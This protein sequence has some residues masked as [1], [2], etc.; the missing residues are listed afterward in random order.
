MVYNFCQYVALSPFLVNYKYAII[1]L[2]NFAQYY[3]TRDIIPIGRFIQHRTFEYAVQL[4]DKIIT[5][6]WGPV[7]FI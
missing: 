5:Y 1:V 6:L 3:C 4:T 2:Q 7:T